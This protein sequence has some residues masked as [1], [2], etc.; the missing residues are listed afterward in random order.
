MLIVAALMLAMLSTSVFATESGNVW[1]NV[2][3]TQE[4]NT[5]VSIVTDTAVTDAYVELSFDNENLSYIGAET[6]SDCVA[7]YSANADESGK[8]KIAWVSSGDYTA[9][10]A[11]VSVMTFIFTGVADAMP[12]MSGQLSDVQGNA[13][14]I[15]ET[16]KENVDKTELTK[17]VLA[18]QG[19]KAENYT[20]ESFAVL[21]AALSAGQAVLEKEQATQNE[22]DEAAKVL[23]DAMDALVLISSA[24][25]DA[26]VNTDELAKLVLKAEGLQKIMYS[27]ESFDAMEA[28]LAD[29]KAVLSNAEATQEQVD[30]AAAQLKSAIDALVLISGDAPDTG[31]TFMTLPMILLVVLSGVGIVAAA[32]LLIS[33][34]GRCAK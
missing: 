4:G 20:E 8:V 14:N 22:V 31:N 5:R 17:A 24:G 6:N 1:L 25:E 32:C 18:A 19:L 10:E 3:E 23:N 30:A 11:G 2:T 7:V 15:R 28:V 34:K 26:V 29:A 21:A 16:V 12:A 13:L 27:E 33:K 9:D